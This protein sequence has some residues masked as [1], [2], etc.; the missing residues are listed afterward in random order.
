MDLKSVLQD[1]L[2]MAICAP[3]EIER[4]EELA[5]ALS[6]LDDQSEGE[7]EGEDIVVATD[8]GRLFKVRIL[9]EEIV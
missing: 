2:V 7:G 3:H 8:D 5:G 6:S 4:D 9:V 1:A